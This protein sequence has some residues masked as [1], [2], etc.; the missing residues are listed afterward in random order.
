MLEAFADRLRVH[1]YQR[2]AARLRRRAMGQPFSG[3]TRER[4]LLVTEPDR[5]P[6]SQIYPFHHYAGDLRRRHDVE[7]REVDIADVLAGR[8][9]AAANAT[10]AAFQ[11]PFDISD[12][13][14][15]GL[16]RRLRDAS[17]G[18]RLVCLDWFSPL[19]LRN[20][21]RMDPLV[22][23]Y[24]KKHVFRDRSRYGKATQGDTNLTDYFGRR[25]GLSEPLVTFPVPEGF[26]NKLILGPSFA[27]A[28]G[29]MQG[30]LSERPS[31]LNRPIDL[32]A[33]FTVE[34]TPWY[35]AMRSDAKAA[36]ASLGGLEILHEGTVPLHK[37]L[38]ELRRAKLCFSPFGYGEVCWRDYEAIMAGAVLVKPD[39]GH[40]ET[41]PD[42][43][44]P[45]ETYVPVRW[46]LADFDDTVRRLSADLPQ[47]ERI[48]KQ[49]FGVLRDWLASD[50]FSRKLDPILCA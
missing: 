33:R 7:L 27:T 16:V 40:V 1:A 35:R 26:L 6:Q 25:A 22:D 11:T 5:I 48:A 24:V 13:D 20:A 18:V 49:A 32:H 2:H 28:P 3:R 8:P 15:H 14:L 39:M 47:R 43:F 45:W 34:G 21:A 42:I 4:L 36:L 44:V 50:G 31:A 41:D 29:I 10:V 12:A 9:I 19:D 38:I 46:D 37:F 30:L 23:F 17:P